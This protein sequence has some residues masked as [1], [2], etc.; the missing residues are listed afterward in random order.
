VKTLS[1]VVVITDQ[2]RLFTFS[3]GFPGVGFFPKHNL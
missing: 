3:L 2:F 1:V